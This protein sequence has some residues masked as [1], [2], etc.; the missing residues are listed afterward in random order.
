MDRDSKAFRRHLAYGFG[1]SLFLLT[2]LLFIAWMMERMTNPPSPQSVITI[3]VDRQSQVT[4]SCHNT[5]DEVFSDVPSLQ[6][7]LTRLC[8]EELKQ[9]RQ[10]SPDREWKEP[11]RLVVIRADTNSDTEFLSR[12]ED[13]VRKAGY[14]NIV[15]D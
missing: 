8:D 15:R 2:C 9:L 10:A 13:A 12:T 4:V 7:H 5:P 1:V 3:H 11:Y 14:T 6:D